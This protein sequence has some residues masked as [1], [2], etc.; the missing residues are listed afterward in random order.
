MNSL[1]HYAICA[2]L[3]VACSSTPIQPPKDSVFSIAFYNV[4]NLF[5][6]RDNP[7]KKDE[8]FL[9][10]SDKKWDKEKYSLK[11]SNLAKAI[12]KIGDD[13]GPEVLGLCEVENKEVLEDLVKQKAIRK[14]KY[15]IVHFES[16]DVRGIDNAL[17][18]KK[19]FFEFRTAKTFDVTFPDD[20]D[21]KTRSILLVTGNVQGEEIHFI[22]NHF[23]SRRGG[24]KESEPRRL[25]AAK[26]L[27]EIV[28]SLL[29]INTNSKVIVMGD[30]ND[31]PTN[32]S[33]REVLKAKGK[34]FEPEQKELYN[35][36]AY[37]DAQK[38]GSYN[39]RGNWQMLD[40]IM[41]SGNVFSANSGLTYVDKSANVYSPEW[42]KQQE[43]EKYR[44]TPLRTF[45]GRK[46]LK[47]FSDHFPVFIHLE[48]K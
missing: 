40:Q 39:Y 42:L 45:A 14:Q 21:Y 3:L 38:K 28:E 10:I 37:W 43:P 41:I 11:L 35:T 48:Y 29:S 12:S 13:N 44:G 19:S 32:K 24:L 15:Q 4:E 27:R 2:L 16:P 47:G 26:K 1:R 31:E 30:F 25:Q 8:D 17:I 9:P 18:Y 34:S 33:I 5:D 20:P 6:L 7:D 23:P 36:L 46:Y 22:V